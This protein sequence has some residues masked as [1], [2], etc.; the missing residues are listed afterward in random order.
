M[1]DTTTTAA[2][3]TVFA[4]LY[5]G[6]DISDIL[7]PMRLVARK[8]AARSKRSNQRRPKSTRAEIHAGRP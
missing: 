8:N 3:P 6:G 1:T 7:M 5:S 4:K 2:K